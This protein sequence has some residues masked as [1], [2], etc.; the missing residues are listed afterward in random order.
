M[1]QR[2]PDKTGFQQIV[3]KSFLPSLSGVTNGGSIVNQ[4]SPS[5]PSFPL[6]LWE[7]SQPGVA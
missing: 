5:S 4:A 1:E 2:N 6:Q 3:A 7:F